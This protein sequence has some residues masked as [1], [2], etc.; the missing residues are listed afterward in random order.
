[1]STWNIK[2]VEEQLQTAYDN[3]SETELL[4]ILKNNS[5][6]FYELYSRKYG[7]RPNFKE[8]AF[9]NKFRCDF[10]W[11]NDNSDGPEWV[12][13]EVEKPSMKLFNKNGDP[14]ADLNHAIEQV[15]S[16]DRYF[17]EN[18]SE[19]AR[20]FGAVSRFRFVLVGGMQ[21]EWQK[22]AAAKWRIQH[23]N[24]SKIEIRSSDVFLRP[25]EVAK[26]Q[27][28]ELWSFEENPI[29]KN[30][31]SLEEYWKECKYIEHWRKY[32]S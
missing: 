21:E 9:G 17:S 5:F 15:K 12:L 19:K 22:E 31:S 4:A 10:A 30:H 8:V 16:W 26:K 28:Q 7:I 24:E 29:S 25:L 27:Y 18:P 11:L 1:M 23:N 3:N 20:I 13:L 14:T 2:E 32:L 6:L